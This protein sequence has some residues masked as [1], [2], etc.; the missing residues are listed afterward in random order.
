[1][2]TIFR[3]YQKKD[4]E[5]LAE[6]IRRT[7]NY[8]KFCSGKTAEKLG[9]A[10]LSSC[11]TNYTYSQVAEKDGKA[12]GIILMKDITK[13]RCTAIQRFKQIKWILSL[14]ITKEGRMACKFFKDIN[15]I[16]NKL[17]DEMGENYQAEL[18]LFALDEKYR[19]EGIGK[20]LFDAA[21]AYTK[22]EQLK[23]FYLFTDTSCNYGFY[24]HQ[25]MCRKGAKE[26]LWKLDGMKEKMTF[27]I[28]DYKI[29]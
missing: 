14:L 11:L 18:A 21:V 19:G 20:S 4:F 28:Y 27:F 17:L 5:Q 9:K 26:Y 2:K 25:G 29:N 15:G 7:W 6:V 22:K 12:V 23:D 8:D 10:F 1:M 24:E 3:E 13:H 16:D